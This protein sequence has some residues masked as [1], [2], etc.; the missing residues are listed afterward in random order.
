MYTASLSYLSAISDFFLA[1]AAR[2][3]RP[4]A[5]FCSNL[6]LPMLCHHHAHHI[7]WWDSSRRTAMSASTPSTT[8]SCNIFS[9]ASSPQRCPATKAMSISK[10]RRR[11]SV[12]L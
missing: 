3:D 8:P 1:I 12:T 2:Q 4:I 10:T 11:H 6:V 9:L 5:N 7:L